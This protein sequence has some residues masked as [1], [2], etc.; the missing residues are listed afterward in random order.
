M[1]NNRDDF[2]VVWKLVRTVE[3]M[4]VIQ[5]HPERYATTEQFGVAYRERNLLMAQLMEMLGERHV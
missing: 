3:R 1:N 4:T 5:Q 2:D